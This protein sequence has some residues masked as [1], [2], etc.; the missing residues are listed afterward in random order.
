MNKIKSWPQ[1]VGEV[2][3][4]LPRNGLDKET[5]WMPRKKLEEKLLQELEAPGVHVCIDGPTGT[6]KT[7]LAKTVLMKNKIPH[8]LIQITKNMTWVDFCFKIIKEPI[9]NSKNSFSAN[10]EFGVNRGLP[11]ALFKL[12]LEQEGNKIDDIELKKRIGESITED[13][14]C[15]LLSSNDITLFIDDFERASKELI[16]RISDMCKLLTE[17]H[18]SKKR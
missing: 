3:N 11:S 1:I 5:F 7:S 12:S 9:N 15:E 17:S 4:T 8:R 18:I 14:I 13:V 2:F 6:G 10:V 16:E